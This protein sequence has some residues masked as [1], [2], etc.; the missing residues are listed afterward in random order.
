MTVEISPLHLQRGSECKRLSKTLE[1][2]ADGSEPV[3]R[4]RKLDQ[5]TRELKV[6]I[7]RFRVVRL[8]IVRGEALRDFL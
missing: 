5:T 8:A 2:L 4:F 3:V 1:D 7:G 6:F